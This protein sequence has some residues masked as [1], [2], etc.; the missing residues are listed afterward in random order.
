MLAALKESPQ[1][2]L[3]FAGQV[4]SAI[5]SRLSLVGVPFA[6]YSIT[7]STFAVGTIG[8]LS[9]IPAAA[10]ALLG[11]P[12]I[13]AMDRRKLLIATQTAAACCSAAFGV[14]ALLGKP[15]LW[16]F[17]LIAAVAGGVNAVDRP[18][19]TAV[20]PNLVAPEKLGG[21]LAV[22]QLVE[23]VSGFAGPALAGVLIAAFGVA[24]VFWI[25][26]VTF[27]PALIAVAA[28]QPLPPEGGAT[29]A[30]LRNAIQ[31]VA[32]LRGRRLI[33][34]LLVIDPMAMLFGLPTAVFPAFG[35]T[36]LG[37]GARTVGLLYAAPGVGSLFGS[38]LAGSAT[39]ISRQGLAILVG[40]ATW[41]LSMALFGLARSLALAIAALAIGGAVDVVATVLRHTA[42]QASI[43]DHVR[44]RLSALQ[45]S[46]VLVAAGSGEFET[47]AV[48]SLAGARFSVVSGGLACV[49]GTLVLGI[50]APSLRTYRRARAPATDSPPE[51][52]AGSPPATEP[53]GGG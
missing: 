20:V 14:N 33:Q 21:A 16:A 18:T 17:Y 41:G 15:Q 26:V 7:H 40:V 4:V 44:G 35:T 2:R 27:L 39:R 50:L 9:V 37:G 36:I 49:V 8:L 28:L 24:T 38:F 19:R 3:L 5:G 47:G 12:L 1:F 11:G 51:S 43:P 34:A 13:D 22:W 23:E 10:A 29:Q 25:D 48:A 46:S 53:A 42:F 30:G 52:S 6:V 31:G 32:Y 45:F